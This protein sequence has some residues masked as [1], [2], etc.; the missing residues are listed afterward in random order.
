LWIRAVQ[1][2]RIRYNGEAMPSAAHFVRHRVIRVD[3][4]PT[5]SE[6]LVFTCESRCLYSPPEVHEV[7]ANTNPMA[8]KRM[9]SLITIGKYDWRAVG[10]LSI[11]KDTTDR[12]VT[13]SSSSQQS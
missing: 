7:H 8:T 10:E 13:Y 3:V 6:A 11:R 1:V 5:S 4:G 9:M 2:L 12:V